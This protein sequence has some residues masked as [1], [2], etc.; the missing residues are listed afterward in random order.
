VPER[1]AFRL[2]SVFFALAMLIGLGLIAVR[3]WPIALLGVLGLIGGWG[4]TAPPLEL[5]YRALGVPLVFL[6]FGPLSVVGAYYAITGVFSPQAAIVSIPVIS[7][8]DSAWQR[9][10]TWPMMRYG[11]GTLDGR[12]PAFTRLRGW[13][14]RVSGAVDRCHAGRAAVYHVAGDVVAAAVGA[15]HSRF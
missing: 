13:S 7:S 2:A 1:E 3:G 9:V 4:Y 11:V 8:R 6:L 5:K 12:P 15:R 10:A 14:W